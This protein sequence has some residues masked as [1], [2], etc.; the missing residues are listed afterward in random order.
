MLLVFGSFASKVS[1]S[2]IGYKS[3]STSVER[4][5]N[6]EHHQKCVRSSYWTNNKV[7]RYQ[8]RRGLRW[9]WKRWYGKW[10]NVCAWG[11]QCAARA[12]TVYFRRRERVDAGRQREEVSDR[13]KISSFQF[14]AHIS[15]ILHDNLFM[16]FAW[17]NGYYRWLWWFTND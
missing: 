8:S 13:V 1:I 17:I 10:F 5:I 14:T 7:S 2:T 12:T 9:P 4:W 16:S 3:L 15:L 11:R 6:D